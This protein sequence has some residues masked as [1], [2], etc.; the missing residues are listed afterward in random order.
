MKKK[1]AKNWV[2]LLKKWVTNAWALFSP[3]KQ[4]AHGNLFELRGADQDEHTQRCETYTN[5]SI[6]SHID[7]YAKMD[8]LERYVVPEHRALK[9]EFPMRSQMQQ[10][11]QNDFT[12][13]AC[14][15]DEI[16]LLF[17]EI[18]SCTTEREQ[19]SDSLCC[20]CSRS[21]F[22]RYNRLAKVALSL[23]ANRVRWMLACSLWSSGLI[24]K[25]SVRGERRENCRAAEEQLPR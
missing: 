5:R 12:G 7:P 21:R 19:N 1:K 2:R 18:L 4:W 17:A 23:I 6:I 11:Q 22:V 10:S 25:Q 13:A 15:A 3:R 8:T 9:M 16:P 24:H 14:L 20:I